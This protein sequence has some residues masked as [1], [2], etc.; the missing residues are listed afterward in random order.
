MKTQN[1]VK[2][3]KVVKAPKVG[4]QAYWDLRAE[5]IARSRA[6]NEKRGET[7]RERRARVKAEKEAIALKAA[8]AAAKAKGKGKAVRKAA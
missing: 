2:A 6:L 7:E 1:K 5:R 8:K 3:N 4:T